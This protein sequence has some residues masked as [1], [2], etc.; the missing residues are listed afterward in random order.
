MQP[1][2]L[3]LLVMLCCFRFIIMAEC[4]EPAEKRLE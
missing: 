1:A 3:V 2:L 4:E